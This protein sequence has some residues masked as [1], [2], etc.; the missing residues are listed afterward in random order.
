M[1]WIPFRNLDDLAFANQVG[2]NY[3]FKFP[4]RTYR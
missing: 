1:I 4:R 2:A 3:R